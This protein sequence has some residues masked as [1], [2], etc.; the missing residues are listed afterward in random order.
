LARSRINA[1]NLVK[2]AGP[3]AEEE[4]P[5]DKFP[6]GHDRH[7]AAADTRKW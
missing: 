2:T 1:G 7:K 5:L 4:D 6:I 3:D